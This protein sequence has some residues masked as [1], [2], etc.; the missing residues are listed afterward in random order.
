MKTN[1]YTKRI[2]VSS[3][4]ALLVLLAATA[5]AQT[6]TNKL[7]IGVYDSRVIAIAYGN[8]PEFQDTLKPVM[9][10]YQKARDAGNEKR[11][12]EIGAQMKLKQRRLHEEGFSPG[13]VIGIMATV[14]DSLPAV[15]R[16][17]GVDVIV[18][19]W[20]VNYQSPNVEIVD[21]TDQ[22]AALFHTS[23]RGKQ[24]L[25]QI[26]AKPPVPIEQITDDMD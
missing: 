18:S 22:V 5:P 24:W 10:E 23:E 26:P 6:Q 4:I 14:K 19:K 11:M 1:I 17:A 25:K 7:R 21:V 20:E 12:K 8:S 2:I 9:A 3:A 16:D 13:S 15:A